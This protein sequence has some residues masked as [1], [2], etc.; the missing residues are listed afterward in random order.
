VEPLYASNTLLHFFSEQ[1]A[2]IYPLVT[3]IAE[4]VELL[5]CIFSLSKHMENLQLL[6][7]KVQWV[8]KI[9]VPHKYTPQMTSPQI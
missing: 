1:A 3:K 2:E 7:E 5:L 9:S 6:T 8:R 4:I